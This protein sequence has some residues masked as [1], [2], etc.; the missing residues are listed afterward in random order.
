MN[1]T[2]RVAEFVPSAVYATMNTRA[3]SSPSALRSGSVPARTVYASARP[4][5]VT[6]WC[7]TDGAGS[8][9]G[10]GAGVGAGAAAGAAVAAGAG[11]SSASA[12]AGNKAHPNAAAT[13]AA[14]LRILTE[15]AVRR[16]A[17]Q[18]P[19]TSSG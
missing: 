16:S 14:R 1:V 10:A 11:S 3:I 4:P 6:V 12:A 7:V 5:T 19:S 13:T 17:P 18:R 8:L 15:P 9:P 2:G